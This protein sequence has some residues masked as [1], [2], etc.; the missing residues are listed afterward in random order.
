VRLHGHTRLCAQRCAHAQGAGLPEGGVRTRGEAGASRLCSLRPGPCKPSRPRLI[1]RPVARGSPF[2]HLH[3]PNVE[4]QTGTPHRALWGGTGL[5]NWFQTAG[6]PMDVIN[7]DVLSPTAIRVRRVAE[8]DHHERPKREAYTTRAFDSR[9]TCRRTDRSSTHRPMRRSGHGRSRSLLTPG[10]IGSDASCLAPD[11]SQTAC[12][13]PPLSV[14]S[15]AE[16]IPLLR[17]GRP[18][19]TSVGPRRTA[20]V[21]SAPRSLP[22]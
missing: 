10:T 16:P 11:S 4:R 3:E 21:G 15:P 12:G 14:C 22:S 19:P 1:P 9:R 20:A 8:G 2:R 7:V 17:R 5:R 6:N 13:L 18:G